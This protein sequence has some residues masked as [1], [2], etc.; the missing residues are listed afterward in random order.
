MITGTITFKDYLEAQKLHYFQA[1]NRSFGVSTLVFMVHFY[2]YRFYKREQRFSETMIY[3]WNDTCLI[4]Q[5]A[6]INMKQDWKIFTKF[7]EN[8]T[9]FLLYD[10]E[11]IFQIFPKRWFQNQKQMTDFRRYLIIQH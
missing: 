8:K 11:G 3:E 10:A 9:L 1:A 5:P 2:L 6:R 4:G 7:R